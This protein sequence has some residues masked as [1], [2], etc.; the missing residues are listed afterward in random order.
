MNRVKLI[1]FIIALLGLP[2]LLLAQASHELESD[3]GVLD[4][5]N[6]ELQVLSPTS[7]DSFLY[8]SIISIQWDYSR[9]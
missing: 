4:G 3:P 7:V 9:T 5:V 8:G 2:P 6:P 1:A